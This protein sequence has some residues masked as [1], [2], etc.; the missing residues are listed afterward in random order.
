MVLTNCVL[1]MK[2][3]VKKSLF[4]QKDL[5]HIVKHDGNDSSGGMTARDKV[6]RNE[7]SI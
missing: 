7:Q 4:M 2:W 1:K 5:N 6:S 3:D